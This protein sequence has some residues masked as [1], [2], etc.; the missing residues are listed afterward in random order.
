MKEY[1]IR[2]LVNFPLEVDSFDKYFR[3]AKNQLTDYLDSKKIKYSDWKLLEIECVEPTD[4][5][6]IHFNFVFDAD[7]YHIWLNKTDGEEVG[8]GNIFN[9]TYEHYNN[10]FKRIQI[11]KLYNVGLGIFWL[12]LRQAK[13]FLIQQNPELANQHP[14]SIIMF[15]AEKDMFKKDVIFG[16]RFANDKDY[17]VFCSQPRGFAAPY[18]M[19]DRYFNSG[20]AR[21]LFREELEPMA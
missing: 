18:K 20:E 1:I 8:K 3:A 21:I 7:N 6:H 17:S 5:N 4:N 9:G 11:G 13:E 10:Q 15:S 2:N 14:Q 16:F 12:N 19:M